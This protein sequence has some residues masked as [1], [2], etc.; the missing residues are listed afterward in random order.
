LAEIESVNMTPLDQILVCNKAQDISE[1]KLA[2]K[3]GTLKSKRQEASILFKEIGI[4]AINESARFKL[5][6]RFPACQALQIPNKGV[7]MFKKVCL[8]IAL[9]FAGSA[10]AQDAT[11]T[12][13]AAEKKL[14]G[15][16]KNSF[17]KKCEKDAAAKCEIASKEKK[18]AGAAK[19][20]FSKKCVKDAVGA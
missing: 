13:S 19:S 16:A 1:K 20:S 8:V 5:G 6:L 17:L 2:D 11:C 7:I 15:A 18:L 9:A 12:A 10:F 14:A 4:P 3:T